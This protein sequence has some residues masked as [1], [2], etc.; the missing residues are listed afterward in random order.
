MKTNAKHYLSLG[1]VTGCML[2]SACVDDSYDLEDVDW[3]IGSNVDLKLPYCSTDS[4]LL[5]N[6]MDLE[7]DGVVQYVWSDKLQ[8]SIFC[9]KQSGKADIQPVNVE[10]IRIRKPQIG[11]IN[12]T[13][14]LSD[15]TSL[16]KKHKLPVKITLPIIGEQ[17]IDIP[18]KEYFYVITAGEAISRIEDN[19]TATN[20]NHDLL[21]I[22]SVTIKENTAT[23][24]MEVAGLP[25]YVTHVYMNNLTIDLPKGLQVSKCTFLGRQVA[26]SRFEGNRIHLTVGE[27]RVSKNEDLTLAITFTGIT[28]GEDFTFDAATHT[29]TIQGGFSIEGSFGLKTSEFNADA[30]SAA[31]A[32]LS[33]EDIQYISEK[34]NL[35]K[36]M[37]ESITFNGTAS[38]SRDIEVE[39]FT[40]D[41]QHQVETIEPIMLDDLPNFLNDDEVVLDL[42]NPI[43]FL[44]AKSQIPA[45]ATT[46]ITVKNVE[47]NISVT[48]P[49][50]S[51]IGDATGVYENQYYLAD[52]AATYLPNDYSHAQRITT[53][54]DEIS[55]LIRK[56]PKQIDIEVAAVRLHA[57]KLSVTRNY[58]IDVE[59][60]VF[61]PI[62]FGSEFL[63]V[64]RDTERGWAEDIKDVEDI[65]FGYLTLTAKAFSD[66]PATTTLKLTPIDENGLTIPQVEV[67]T[68]NVPAG[69]DGA[70]ISFTIKPKTGFTL[71]DILNGN[72]Q[73]GVKK[74]D[75][76]QYEARLA[77][78]NTG[79]T[80]KRNAYL[81]LRQAQ[82]TIKGGVTYDAN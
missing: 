81:I 70:D 46:S 75:G 12:A 73:K 17:T 15:L 41:L 24:Q 10:D 72:P 31:I 19:A 7:D 49:N 3:T 56:I 78:T 58:E 40:G 30:V 28:E 33:E 74:I 42:D 79:G 5:R 13:V 45:T 52:T 8:D 62:S 25:D 4:I 23:L 27:T 38:F 11:N 34:Q 65:D 35:D 2:L 6:I 50:I 43:L 21:S 63:L 54:G 1:V 57:E 47:R 68:V 14:L 77:G 48:A 39:T 29:A 9:V 22:E 18:D 53:T 80:L 64:Y 69:A 16:S 36:L 66:L 67:N 32:N 37:P 20:I 71:N 51:V 82:V 55:K 44:K 59:Y 26:E 76:V 60:E 61:A